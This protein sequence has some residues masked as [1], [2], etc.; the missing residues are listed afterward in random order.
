MR[1]SITGS[2]DAAE[3]LSFS[4]AIPRNFLQIRP[5]PRGRGTPLL[6]ADS[7]SITPRT[8]LYD[9]RGAPRPPLDF[10]KETSHN[11]LLA[12]SCG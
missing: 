8:G 5:G 10:S 6:I 7:L 4:A 3:V 1:S 2:A 12:A 11:M 9:L